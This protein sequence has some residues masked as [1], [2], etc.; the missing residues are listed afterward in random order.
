MALELRQRLAIIVETETA[1]G[2]LKI[3]MGRI[4]K[5]ADDHIFFHP[6]M[7]LVSSGLERLGKT[8]LALRKS[9]IEGAIPRE[10]GRNLGHN[11]GRIYERVAQDSYDAEF[12]A[13]PIPSNDHQYLTDNIR[14][15]SIINLLSDYGMGG[16]YY[17]L[18]G[19]LGIEP[20][21]DEPALR[22]EQIEGDIARDEGIYEQMLDPR[23]QPCALQIVSTR[24][25]IYIEKLIAAIARLYWWGQLGPD[26]TRA[27][28]PLY[29]YLV[30]EE[31]VFGSTKYE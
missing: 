18:D 2:L 31:A 8:A 22:W 26:G 7:L 23:Q 19:L 4:Q 6:Q 14:L 29:D 24:I 11:L 15:Q 17:D 13:Q 21:R 3:G 27:G 12:L 28:S 16:R 9:H 1:V 5:L 10:L 20:G 25:V 30:M